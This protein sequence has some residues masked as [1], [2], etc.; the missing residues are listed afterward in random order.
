MLKVAVDGLAFYAYHGVPDA[1]RELGHR[2]TADIEV[3]CAM[4]ACES[5]EIEDGVD[6]IQ[7]AEILLET[8]EARQYHTL[9]ALAYAY[10]RQ[11]LR[12]FPIVDE[13]SIHLSKPMPPAPIIGEAVGVSLTLERN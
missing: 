7:L 1:E 12:Q 5:D 8:S 9:E 6:Y 13:V 11:I 4:D 2:L 10:C 3:L